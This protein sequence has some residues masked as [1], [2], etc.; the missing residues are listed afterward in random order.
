MYYKKEAFNI[1]W[2]AS[3]FAYIC[4]MSLIVL[5]KHVRT[6]PVTPIM[7]VGTELKKAGRH[8]PAS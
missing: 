5:K 4:A 7:G 2:P 6:S 3:T 1:P 8:S